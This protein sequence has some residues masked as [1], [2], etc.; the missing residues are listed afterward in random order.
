M[1]DNERLPEQ[2]QREET[3][4]DVT[5]LDDQDLEGAAGGAAGGE[6]LTPL[7]DVSNSSCNGNCGC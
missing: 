7:E 4:V 1:A 3:Q 2:G 6:N 5:E